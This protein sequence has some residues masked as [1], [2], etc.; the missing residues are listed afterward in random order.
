MGVGLVLAVLGLGSTFAANIFINGAGTTS[1]FGQGVTQTVYCGAGEEEVDSSS[2]NDE[3]YQDEI[4]ITPFSA[5]IPGTSTTTAGRAGVP[6]SW[7][8]PTWTGTPKF[9]EVDSTATKNSF[10]STYVNDASGAPSSVKGYWIQTSRSS[11]SWFKETN[12]PSTGY[13]FAP[14]AVG[15]ENTSWASRSLSATT[16]GSQKYGYW[17]FEGWKAGSMSVAVLSTPP[18]T[19]KTAPRFEVRGIT[20]SDIDENC[21]GRDFVLSAYDTSNAS[22]NLILNKPE[23]AVLY[24]DVDDASQS[25][26]FS[27]DRNGQSIDTTGATVTESKG[28][29]VIAFETGTRMR[30]ELL[31][32]IVIE[33]QDD[34]LDSS[35]NRSD[36]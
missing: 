23:I 9:Q 13:V 3:E 22:M 30:A 5:F 6:S 33:T 24:K 34:L 7:I 20:V 27:F 11:S 36:D 19:I 4:T 31:K 21:K 32:N 29:I 1:E 28:K 12:I 25:A 26:T 35:F 17:K 16:S 15:N 14:Q 8:A 10:T 2:R 18:V